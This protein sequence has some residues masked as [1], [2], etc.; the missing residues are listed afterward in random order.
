MGIELGVLVFNTIFGAVITL[1]KNSQED[2]RA[3]R[4][5]TLKI[6]SVNNRSTKQAREYEG[7]PVTEQNRIR[8]SKKVFK[9]FGKE[10][11][12]ESSVN[13]TG[14]YKASTGFHITRRI[15][16][17][18]CVF[19]VIVLPM[20]LPV[21]YNI[22]YSYGYIENTWSMLPWVDETPVVKW[23]SFGDGINN[24]VVTPLMINVM[25]SIIGLFFGNQITKR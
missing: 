11:G 17:L 18:T 21:F 12:W 3:E 19:C 16:A 1:W 4:E 23:I 6:A 7:I 13:D 9:I 10:F 22:T 14:K 8:K 5:N 25:L 20:L 24:V 15:I 2:R